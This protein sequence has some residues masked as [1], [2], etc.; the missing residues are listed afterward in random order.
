MPQ[1]TT[2]SPR[3][4]VRILQATLQEDHA[5][6]N[7]GRKGASHDQWYSGAV[8]QSV[9][10]GSHTVSTVGQTHSQYSGA[11]TQSVQWGS[12]TVSIMGQ[13]HSTVG[14]IHSTV[15]QSHSQY[16][17]A[18][19]QY[20]GADTQSV[21]WG[22][23]TVSTVGQTHSTVGQIYST[24]YTTAGCNKNSHLSKLAPPP[25]HSTR[26]VTQTGVTKAAS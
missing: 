13:S 20:S 14:Q 4:P 25:P 6:N 22:S 5:R 10:W 16:I 19:T 17:G 23:H 18:D 1:S 24:T 11:D 26:S 12:H 9:Q 2:S 3:N 8:T 15:G 7:A 21:Q